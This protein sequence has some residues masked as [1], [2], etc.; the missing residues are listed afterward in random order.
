VKSQDY[1]KSNPESLGLGVLDPLGVDPLPIN[2]FHAQAE[3]DAIIAERD[4]IIAERDAILK[5][6]LWRWTKGIRQ[7][8]SGSKFSTRSKL[9][10]EKKSAYKALQSNHPEPGNTIQSKIFYKMAW[11]RNP[12][13]RIYADKWLVRKY[14]RDKV[15]EE[16]L[17]PLLGVYR[18]PS[19]ID[20]ANLP[21]EFVLKVNH[22]SGGVIVVSNSA[23][24]ENRLPID[25]NSVGWQRF[26]VQPENFS[27]DIAEKLLNRWIKMDYEWWLGRNPEWAYKNIKRRIL[28]EELMVSKGDSGL[29][30]FKIY[31]FDGNPQIIVK[32]AGSVSEKSNAYYHANWQWIEA[33]YLEKGTPWSKIQPEDP[34]KNL[35][36][37]IKISKKL[38]IETDFI[39][40]DFI[41]DG[42]GS[43]RVGEL[44]N[45][46]TSGQMEYTPKDYAL[47]LGKDWNPSYR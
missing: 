7:L 23:P 31:C 21:E 36:K 25:I 22:G 42:F 16:Y 46:P 10:K 11:D 37:L 35:E 2:S 33:S 17:V 8:V 32:Q 29:T 30:E 3:R 41:D 34:P 26:Q 38:S 20:Y 47:L 28:V 14:I 43:L 9:K 15:G 44:T 24:E 18:R 5:T 6:K 19:A 1:I 4:A 39:R 27:P 40:V 13:I 12:K 45:Y